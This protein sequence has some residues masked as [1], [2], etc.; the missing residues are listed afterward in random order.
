MGKWWQRT[1]GRPGMSWP[2]AAAAGLAAFPGLFLWLSLAQDG[3]IGGN[4]VGAL[5]GGAFTVV[6]ARFDPRTRGR[7]SGERDRARVRRRSGRR[8]PR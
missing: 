7:R 6:L 4:L 3:P 8:K 5:G 1:D 2:G